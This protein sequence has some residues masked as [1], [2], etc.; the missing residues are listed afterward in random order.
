MIITNMLLADWVPG[1]KVSAFI[2]KMR[3]LRLGEG[4]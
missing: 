4:K 1:T 2:C 3:K